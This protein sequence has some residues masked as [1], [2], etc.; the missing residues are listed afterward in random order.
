MQTIMGSLTALILLF[1]TAIH[2]YW[3]HGGN[4]PG[5]TRQDLVDQVFGEGT[6]FPSLMACYAVAF[7]LLCA[8]FIA[9]TSAGII[10][11]AAL[12]NKYLFWMNIVVAAGFLIRGVAAYHPK[13]EKKWTPIF[14]R[15]NRIIYS[16]LCI[17]LGLSFIYLAKS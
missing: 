1:L 8:T 16:P 11:I 7:I 9:L 6:Q 13:L 14:V 5:K 10:H 2:I 15:Y 12:E 17:F 4:W 3:G